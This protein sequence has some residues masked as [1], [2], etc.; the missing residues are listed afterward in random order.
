MYE[1]LNENLEKFTWANYNYIKKVLTSYYSKYSDS[2]WK[3]Y[4]KSMC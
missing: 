2:V 3:N 4:I 1:G